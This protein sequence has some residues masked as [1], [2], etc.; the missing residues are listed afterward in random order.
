MLL[1]DAKIVLRAIAD[2]QAPLSVILWGPTGI[3]KSS[4]VKQLAKELNYKLTDIRLSQREAVDILGMPYTAKAKINGKEMDALSHHPPEWFL[5]SLMEGNTVLFLDELNR[6]RPEVLQAV[7]E[8]ALDRK[9]NGVKLPDSVLIVSACNPPDA[10]YDTVDFDDALTARFMHLH[11]KTNADIWLEWAKDKGE[12]NKSNVNPFVYNFIVQHK[13]ALNVTYKEDS[14]FPVEVKPCSRSWEFVSLVEEL[15]FSKQQEFLMR[16]CVRGL[17]GTE[18]AQAY[19]VSRMDIDKP[20][21][22]EELFSMT[23]EKN[24]PIRQRVKRYA[25]GVNGKIATDLLKETCKEIE[26]SLLQ[27]KSKECSEHKEQV[28]DFLEM[29]PRDLALATLKRIYRHGDWPDAIYSRPKLIEALKELRK[30]Q[31]SGRLNGTKR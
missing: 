20:I 11:V 18:F 21:S 23:R 13:E 25:Q 24:D 3:G 17:V 4:I 5:R 15:G 8:L 6:A 16:E 27:D 7:F 9:L 29:I 31:E 10:R 19:M 22:L 26:R 28:L 14:E 12:T 1:T 30:A 2:K